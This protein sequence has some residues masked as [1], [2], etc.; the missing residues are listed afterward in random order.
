MKDPFP[1]GSNCSRLV[2]SDDEH[3]VLKEEDATNSDSIA[4]ENSKKIRQQFSCNLEASCDH[5]SGV[6]TVKREQRSS[7]A[8]VNYREPSLTSKL[9]QG[10]KHTFS[11]GVEEA[12]TSSHTKS[13]K[14]RSQ[15]RRSS[16]L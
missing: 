11:F 13:K 2:E 6:S 7:R 1:E 3:Y 10:S 5:E 8:I 14:E 15:R 16:A 4:L 12:A 9:R